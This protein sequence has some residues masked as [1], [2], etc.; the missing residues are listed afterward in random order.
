MINDTARPYP[1]VD[2]SVTSALKVTLPEN[3][4]N[5]LTLYAEAMSYSK[6]DVIKE[7]VREKIAGDNA[8]KN[9]FYAFKKQ[10]VNEKDYIADLKESLK[11]A[12]KGALVK[13]ALHRQDQPNNAAAC[14]CH[15][16][17]YDKDFVYLEISP[18]APYS[19]M[20][21]TTNDV[22]LESGTLVVP[23]EVVS[24]GMLTTIHQFI[25]KVPLIYVWDIDCNPSPSILS[26]DG[27]SSA[28]SF[29]FNP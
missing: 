5:D 4:F 12:K 22:S 10:R 16:A 17:K 6:S 14:I 21:F 2:S 23:E 7:A 11:M 9:R 1:E 3:I 8:W 18:V 25:Y 24:Q 26:A 20:D 28:T 13:I 29:A 27:M 19:F 15:L